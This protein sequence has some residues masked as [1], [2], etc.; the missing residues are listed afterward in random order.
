M[1]HAGLT[2]CYGSSVA[3]IACAVFVLIALA[4]AAPA[5]ARSD[6]NRVAGYASPAGRWFVDQQGRVLTFHGFVLP[7][8]R[9]PYII[10]AAGFGADDAGFLAR[11]G[12]NLMQLRFTYGA[13][14]PRPGDYDEAY[15]DEVVRTVK[16]LTARGIRVV[17]QANQGN[18]GPVTHGQGFPDWATFT[19]GM[20]NPDAGFGPNFLLNPALLRAWDALWA[21]RETARGEGIQEGF[22]KGIAQIV[23]RLADD[24]LVLGIDILNEPWLGSRYPSCFPVGRLSIEAGC[25]AFDRQQLTPFYEKVIAHIRPLMPR[26]ILFYEPAPTFDLGLP[27]FLRNIGG[28]ARTAF[29][30]HAYCALDGGGAGLPTL[31]ESSLKERQCATEEERIFD[32]AEAHSSAEDV[33][34]ISSEFGATSSVP[35]VARLMRDHERHQFSW[36][37]AAYCCRHPKIAGTG[38]VILDPAQPPTPQNVHQGKLAELVRPYPAALAGTPVRMSFDA[39]TARYALTYDTARAG[40]GRFGR[41]VETVVNVPARHYPHGYDVE[42]RGG[43]VVSA[44]GSRLLRVVT[45]EG[46]SR[47]ELELRPSTATPYRCVSRRLITMHLATVPRGARGVRASARMGDRVLRVHGTRRKTVTVDL[48]G[49]GRS[50]VR[51]RATVS[52]KTAAGVHVRRQRTAT[53][54]TCTPRRGDVS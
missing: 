37:Y 52:W 20:P 9:P 47:V 33:P 24:P 32:N 12:F 8:K 29:A 48:R 3:R 41:G 7:N 39:K 28:E 51:V 11:E 23:G 19:D 53:Y 21:N 34:L 54:A 10:S 6:L 50:R 40:G 31:P 30:F 15:V 45:D 38:D 16:L 49:R 18:F 44:A 25:R 1:I 46:A 36:T 43:R 26:Q 4:A 13:V 42:V 5:Q 14:E 35:S 27:T 22:A 17:L 2:V